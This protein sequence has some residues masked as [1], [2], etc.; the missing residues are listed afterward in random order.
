MGS[1]GNLGMLGKRRLPN[2]L[3][4]APNVVFTPTSGDLDLK[5]LGRLQMSCAGAGATKLLLNS[6]LR[7]KA[8][9]SKSESSGSGLDLTYDV[10]LR[11]RK[12][13]ND[14]MDEH[15]LGTESTRGLSSK[16]GRRTACLLAV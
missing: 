11:W 10:R 8:E 2:G 6:R 12:P 3:L 4:F 1:L 7:F 14:A 9:V 15:L 13:G 5:P 16:G